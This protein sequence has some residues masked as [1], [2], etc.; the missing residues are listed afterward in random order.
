MSKQQRTKPTTTNM[1]VADESHKQPFGHRCEFILLFDCEDGNPNGDP[2][3]NNMPRIDPQTGHGLVSDVSLKWHVR[4]YVQLR[5][6]QVFIQPKTNLN[7]FI[8]EAHEKTGGRAAKPTKSKIEKAAA[9]MCQQYFDVRTFGAVMTTGANAGQVRGPVQITFARSVDPILPIEVAI[10]RGAVTQD[11][12][13][14]KS[15]EEYKTWED[16]QDAEE[17]RTMGRKTLSPYGLYV[18]RGFISAFDAQVT[19]FSEPDFR[20]LL[21][22]LLNMFDHAHSSSK[23]RLSTRRLIVFKH[24]GQHGNPAQRAQEAMLGCAPAH[25]L[26]DLGQVVEIVLKDKTRVPRRFSDYQVT[27]D[28]TKVPASVKLID[29]EVWDDVAISAL[30]ANPK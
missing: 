7:R 28:A 24:V 18:A 2:D 30:S 10:T 14:A 23:G 4:N 6:E 11:L 20:L 13:K 25:R 1:G 15:S 9:W 16:E 27:V 26:V 5:G 3:S 12:P 22:S 29:L 8:L 19:G 17:L 21:E